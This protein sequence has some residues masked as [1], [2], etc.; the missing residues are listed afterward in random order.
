M[1]IL[2]LQLAYDAADP[3]R[4]QRFEREAKAISALNRP[5]I[6]TLYDVGRQGATDF[7]A[8]DPARLRTT[9]PAVPIA[10]QEIQKEGTFFKAGFSVSENGILAFQSTSDS[11]SRLVWFS[12]SGKE[13]GQIA[14][15][16]YKDPRLSPDG[17]FLAVSIASPRGAPISLQML[18]KLSA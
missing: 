7:L 16:V 6:C 13:L 2:R 17:R 11:S 9:G 18:S 1:R 5:N 3:A 4:R 12:P 14:E 15:A 10:T 8:F